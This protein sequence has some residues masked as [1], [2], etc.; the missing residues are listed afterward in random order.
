MFLTT[1]GFHD[2]PVNVEANPNQH[3]TSPVHVT[4]NDVPKEC[5]G[6]QENWPP[7]AGELSSFGQVKSLFHQ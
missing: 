7:L 5:E 1:N 6:L 2:F 4:C 3:P